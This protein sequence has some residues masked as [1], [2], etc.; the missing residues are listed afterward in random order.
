M[1]KGHCVQ[2]VFTQAINDISYDL[3]SKR[4]RRK[5][6]VIFSKALHIFMFCEE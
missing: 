5:L 3:S 4:L 2:V 6:Y 1:K